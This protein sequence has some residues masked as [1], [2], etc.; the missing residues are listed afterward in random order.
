[1]VR[2]MKKYLFVINNMEIGGTR[3]S[4]LN[5]LH[6]LV[7]E[8]VKVDLLL[9]SP[10]GILKDQIDNKV[11]QLRTPYMCEIIYTKNSN[12]RGIRRI[13]GYALSTFQKICGKDIVAKIAAFEVNKSNNIDYDLVIGFQE[14]D[15]VNVS[16][17]IQGK[18][19]YC[20]IHNNAT[21]IGTNGL[22]SLNAFKQM[23]KIFFVAKTAQNDFINKIPEFEAKTDVIKNTLN[24]NEIKGKAEKRVT[25]LPNETDKVLKLVS[26]GRFVPQK[27]FYRILETAI[28]L[29][30]SQIPFKWLVVGDGPERSSFLKSVNEMGLT[31][32]VISLGAKT[33]PYPYIKWADLLV[34][35]SK[36]ESQPMV[37]LE[38]LVLGNPVWS[39]NFE[40]AAELLGG[41]DFGYL[42]PNTDLGVVEG[43]KRILD[44]DLY[45][46]MSEASKQF[47]YNNSSIV[48]SILD[49]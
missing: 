19:H 13:L 34:V 4:L 27:A 42:C 29:K 10:H 28:N 22:G 49:L 37:I 14:G 20:W 1:M 40:S 36:Y 46:R 25:D 33:N 24:I 30:E 18:K 7:N 8:D 11:T 41:K 43:M 45:D 38:G 26:V 17:Y 23:T 6:L 12:L 2:A 47:S 48:K 39:T 9:L 32:Q 21:D 15:T 16:A 3:S 44:K 5:L 35:T 31:N